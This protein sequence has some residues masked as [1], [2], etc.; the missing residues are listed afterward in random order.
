MREFKQL[1]IE[2]REYIMVLYAQGLSLTQIGE[3]VGKHK[4]TISREIKRNK[5]EKGVYS[6]NKAQKKAD[7]RQKINCRKP[8]I[9]KC[10]AMKDY[11]ESKLKIGWSPEQIEGRC[12]TEK[13]EMVSLRTIYRSI[14]V[15][16]LPKN[17]KKFLPFRGRK[18]KNRGEEEK[19]GKIPN[20]T[21]I[22]ARPIEADL[23]IKFGHLEGDTVC[24]KR[25]TG[26]FGTSVD[27]A[28]GLFFAFKLSDNSAE[29]WN[30]GFK[31]KM[32]NFTLKTLTLDNG[33]EFANHEELAAHFGIKTYFCDPYSP[34]QKGAV[35]NA[36][37]LL[38]WFFPKR[39]S[40]E[41][42]SQAD[43]DLVVDLINNRPRKRL[44]WLT[45][46]EYYQKFLKC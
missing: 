22:S 13:R 41:N 32:K 35:E 38:R 19:R 39:T 3:K 43:L 40:F 5:D 33:K 26:Y 45:P 14:K 28:S 23:R 25:E 2:D 15:G 27:K 29:N 21:N 16:I 30:K 42:V 1:K 34:W 12:K 31:K 11:I 24:G 6:A 36:N 46:N 9:K 17:W 37:R 18:R 44:L 8:K 4:S 10:S 7:K 20:T